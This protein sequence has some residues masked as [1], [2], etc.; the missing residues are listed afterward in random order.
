MKKVFLLLAS[1]LFTASLSAQF[2]TTASGFVVSGGE[3][4]SSAFTYGQLFATEEFSAPVTAFTVV[5]G[6]QQSQLILNEME[7]EMCENVNYNKDGWT[8][9]ATAFDADHSPALFGPFPEQGQTY[10][11]S[12]NADQYTRN[13]EFHYDSAT[14]LTLTVN[15]VYTVDDTILVYLSEVPGYEHDG[16]AITGTGMNTIVEQSEHGCDSTVNLMVYAVPC[17]LDAY[18]HTME[19]PGVPTWPVTVDNEVSTLFEAVPA[20]GKVTITSTPASDAEYAYPVGETTVVTYTASVGGRELTCD[21]DVIINYFPCPAT[22]D[23]DG[24]TYEVTRVLYDCWTKTNLRNENYADGTPISSVGDPMVYNSVMYS[25]E[26]ANLSNYGR[27]YT[28]ASATRNGATSGTNPYDGE[29]YVQGICPDGWHLPSDAKFEEILAVYDADQL[30]ST[31]DLW[32][33]T[34]GSN[35]STFSALPGGYYNAGAGYFEQMRVQAYFW[36]VTP[37]GSPETYYNLIIGDSCG[38]SMLVPANRAEG[39]SIRCLLNY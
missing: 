5:A 22:V 24:Y 33:P 20:D 12:Y 9:P 18:T 13:T 27:L 26:A 39:K 23:L 21:R 28:W 14:V 38:P 31:S 25:D 37:A 15:P 1:V 32:L 19:H 29:D 2:T 17:P 35:T 6:V 3:A 16:H 10:D 11:L 8:I 7:D 30:K 4:G 36:T 34:G